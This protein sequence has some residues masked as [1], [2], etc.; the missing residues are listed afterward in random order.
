M[1]TVIVSYRIS[2]KMYCYI[3]YIKNNFVQVFKYF[4]EHVYIKQK[5]EK[6]WS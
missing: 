6:G 4:R 3:Q 1:F 5:F 2:Y